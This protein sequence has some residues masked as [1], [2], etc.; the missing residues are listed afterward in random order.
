[1]RALI[2]RVKNASIS[3]DD[4]AHASIEKGLLVFVGIE[5][6]DESTDVDYLIKKVSQLRI[7]NDAEGNM[8]LGPEEVGAEFLVVSQFTLHSS[9]KK[10]NRPSFLKAAKPPKA[11]PLY[12]EFL[13][14]L[15]EISKNKV[16][17]GVFGADMQICLLNDG[18][19]TIIID[20]K[21]KE[22]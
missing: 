2:Q 14:K 1:L 20:S 5:E 18:P 3:I 9:T 17:S 6:N 19:V 21:N 11:I 7:F 13:F 8:N 4:K 16:E 12:E 22:L 10:G 15:K